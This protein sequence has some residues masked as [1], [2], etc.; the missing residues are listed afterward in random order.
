MEG[1]T[2]KRP[3]RAS[4]ANLQAAGR[5]DGAELSQAG[6][7]QWLLVQSLE[8]LTSWVTLGSHLASSINGNPKRPLPRV[9]V[10]VKRARPGK[11]LD[12]VSGPS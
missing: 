11:A 9:W 6:Q 5:A 10:K 3:L 8:F 1:W 4:L 7:V 12:T 2:L